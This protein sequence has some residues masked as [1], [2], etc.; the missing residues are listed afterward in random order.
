MLLLPS[1][2]MVALDVDTK[3]EALKL[4]Q[5]LKPYTALFKVGFQLFY[6]EGPTIITDLRDL[7][8][9]V[10]LDLKLHDIPNTVLHALRNLSRLGIFMTNVHVAGGMEMMTQALIGARLGAEDAGLEPPLILGVTVLTSLSASDVQ[11]DIGIPVDVTE[12]AVRRA[13][14]AQEAGLDGVV[15]SPQETE[16]IRQACGKDFL[17]VT[18]GIRPQANGQD[19]QR[20]ATSPAQAVQAGSDLLIVGRPVIKAP[21]PARALAAII[22]EV[23]RAKEEAQA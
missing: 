17:I 6:R 11:Q 2:V 9:K 1:P 12:L 20:R 18:P 7:G 10:F 23:S 22:D 16:P 21:E 8:V 14:L 5:E 13:Q 19:D 3:R 15:A 4:V